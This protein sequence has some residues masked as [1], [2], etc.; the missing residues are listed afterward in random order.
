M[1]LITKI[2]RMSIDLVVRDGKPPEEA[3]RMALAN[4]FTS[5]ALAVKN[6]DKPDYWFPMF[7]PMKMELDSEQLRW[8]FRL[9]AKFTN[10]F[11]EEKGD[12]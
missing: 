6:S 1:T 7:F 11:D 4:L 3:L 9:V 8:D 2:T 12:E 5:L 10:Q